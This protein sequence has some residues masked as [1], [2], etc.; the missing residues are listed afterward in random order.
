VVV[1]GET[2]IAVPDV[3]GILPGVITPVP[4]LKTGVKVVESPGEIEAAPAVSD[5]AMGAGGA[6]GCE[7]PPP[8]PPPPQAIMRVVKI[9]KIPKQKR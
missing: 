3:A 2:G 8:P 1:V 4:L 7:D 9:P 5:V 6:G